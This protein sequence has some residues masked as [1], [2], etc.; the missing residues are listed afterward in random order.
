M[1]WLRSRRPLAMNMNYLVRHC[2][3]LRPR[4]IA[5]QVPTSG[6]DDRSLA[7]QVRTLVAAH[8][9]GEISLRREK[10]QR[11]FLYFLIHNRDLRP[12]TLR[13]LRNVSRRSSGGSMTAVAALSLEIR[14][15]LGVPHPSQ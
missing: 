6:P 3:S 12:V 13:H 2:I 14:H 15:E 5:A 9:P 10:V 1:L 8:V 4:D 7:A 11:R